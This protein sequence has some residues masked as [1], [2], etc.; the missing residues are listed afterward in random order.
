MLYLTR[1]ECGKVVIK[2][3]IICKS[4]ELHDE[5]LSFIRKKAQEDGHTSILAPDLGL[6]QESPLLIITQEDGVEITITDTPSYHMEATFEVEL[7][8][9]VIAKE[10]ATLRVTA[11]SKAEAMAIIKKKVKESGIDHVSEQYGYKTTVIHGYGDAFYPDYKTPIP[12]SIE[13]DEIEMRPEYMVVL[14]LDENGDISSVNPYQYAT[15]FNETSTFAIVVATDTEDATKTPYIESTIQ[16]PAFLFP[17]IKTPN[18]KI[19]WMHKP[20]C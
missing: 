20:N 3:D 8:Y 4:E 11:S 1:K 10:I 13:G 18:C 19:V 12:V 16:T 2:D 7:S 6:P 15:S 5:V 14:N 17:K 9:P